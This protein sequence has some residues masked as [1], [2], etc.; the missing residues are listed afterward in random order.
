MTSR[1]KLTALALIGAL[2]LIL[3]GLMNG[4]SGPS[5]SS[6]DGQVASKIEPRVL[7][8]TANG[9]STS[10]LILLSDQ[11]DVHAAYGMQDQDARGWYVYR[12]LS[13]NAERTQAGIRALLQAA[14]V[15]YQSF[16]VANAIL[17]TGGRNLIT[18]LAARSDVRAI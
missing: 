10:F 6:A 2:L 15:K 11:A 9:Q 12:T 4:Q 13:Q 5:G 1:K 3:G 18:T 17:C 16:W 8:A 14:G 7:A